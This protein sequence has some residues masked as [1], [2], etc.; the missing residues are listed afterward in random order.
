MSFPCRLT[1]APGGI[2]SEQIALRLAF[3]KQTQGTSIRFLSVRDGKNV[4]CGKD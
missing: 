3:K 1:T 4:A 2:S